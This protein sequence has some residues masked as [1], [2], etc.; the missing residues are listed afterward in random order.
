MESKLNNKYKISVSDLSVAFTNA[1]SKCYVL[2]NTSIEVEYNQIFCILGTNGSG[3]TTLLTTIAG[4]IQPLAGETK[5]NPI[6]TYDGNFS[7][8]VALLHQDYR[9]TNYPWA[10]VLENV[11]YPLRFKKTPEVERKRGLQILSEFLPEVDPLKKLHTL[12]GGQEQLVAIARA[13]VAQIDVLLADEPLSAVDPI[14]ALRAI[15]S[16]DKIRSQRTFP[17]IWISHNIDQ[18]LLIADRIGLLSSHSH[19][20]EYIVENPVNYPR[21]LAD[22]ENP[23][24]I[25]LKRKILEFLITDNQDANNKDESTT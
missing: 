18:A 9:K 23:E 21:T 7:P 2:K 5:I 11:T 14:R 17:V 22:L 13:L 1:K 3:K 25:K 10:T 15:A 20:F 12:S 4:L 8:T 16:M 24:V 19:G 6:N